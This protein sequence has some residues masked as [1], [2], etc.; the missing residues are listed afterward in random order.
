MEDSNSLKPE[1]KEPN[2]AE[3]RRQEKDAS[4]QKV[5][6]TC[7]ECKEGPCDIAP[8]VFTRCP[9]CNCPARFVVKAMADDLQLEDILGK[10]PAL[11][12]FEYLYDTPNYQ[13][14]LV[15]VGASCARC[16]VFYTIARDKMKKM[17]LLVPRKPGGPGQGLI[18]G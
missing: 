6:A 3:R 2:R 15:A 12:S 4:K 1:E 8:K 16:G 7:T 18:H 17:P 10:S 9:V 13:V 14:K 11:F 5:K